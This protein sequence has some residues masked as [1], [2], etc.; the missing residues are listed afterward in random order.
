MISDEYIKVIR[1]HQERLFNEYG[2]YLDKHFDP[3]M[4]LK[5]KEIVAEISLSRDII[6]QYQAF[7]R[8]KCNSIDFVFIVYSPKNKDDKIY[9]LMIEYMPSIHMQDKDA[10]LA[11]FYPSRF[12]HS[13]ITCDAQLA[14]LGRIEVYCEHLYAAL[15]EIDAIAENPIEYFS[16]I[17]KT[18]FYPTFYLNPSEFYGLKIAKTMFYPRN[19]A[20]L[21][22]LQE[23]ENR[24]ISA[25]DELNEIFL[26][27]E[28]EMYVEELKLLERLNKRLS[29]LHNL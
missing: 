22:Y 6:L 16:K 3:R 11:V 27:L 7:K 4:W 13:C 8:G 14:S 26:I 23:I 18:V 24:E 5:S 25:T 19:S 1:S 28:R 9:S 17:A 2:I 15:R 12:S 20:L 21:E 10:E 29:I